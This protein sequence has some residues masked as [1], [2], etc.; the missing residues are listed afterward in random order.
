MT[1]PEDVLQAQEAIRRGETIVVPTD[2][3]YGLACAAQDQGGCARM[4]SLKGR[5]AVQP[6]AVIFADIGH[7]LTSLPNMSTS[8]RR[9]AH[10][11]LP[12]PFTLLIENPDR[13][14]PWLCSNE[15]SVIGVRVPLGA[16][17][18]PPLAATSANLAGGN[19]ARSIE[20]L[21][22]A[23]TSAIGAIVDRGPILEGLPST[24]LHLTEWEHGG[25]VRVVRDPAARAE[26]ALARL[27]S[28][29]ADRP[30]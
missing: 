16:L 3:V 13:F 29:K 7:L 19:P 20:E 30:E 1:V 18:L 6:T 5:S 12:G 11:L 27:T 15:G 24:I 14:A 10:A 2:T 25:E 17:D 8:A 4:Y 22:P 28:L 21:H 26:S 9:A 23:L